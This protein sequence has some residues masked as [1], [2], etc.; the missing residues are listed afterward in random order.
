MTKRNEIVTGAL[1]LAALA[2]GT[3]AALAQDWTGTY[4]GLSLNSNSG[5][6]PWNAGTGYNDYKLSNKA[7][8]GA[9][10]GNRWNAGGSVM[11]VELDLSQSGLD[12]DALDNGDIYSM[13][14]L[15]DAKVSVGMPMGKTMVYGFAGLSSSS[16]YAADETYKVWGTNI[17][18]GADYM[19]SDTMSVGLE[20]MNRQWQHGYDPDS[21]G[22]GSNTSVALRASFHF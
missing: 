6:T 8:A 3:D 4:A 11:G 5:S 13:G 12:A 18:L 20:V 7:I 16:L 22:N 19:V 9:F 17:G 1:S 10:I 14:S 15:V 21:I 2:V